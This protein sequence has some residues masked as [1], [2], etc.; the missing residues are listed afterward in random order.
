MIPSKWGPIIHFFKVDNWAQCA[1]GPWG[2]IVLDPTVCPEKMNRWGWTP[3]TS[4]PGAQLSVL[5]KCSVGPWAVRPQGLNGW[6][7]TV[8]GPICLEPPHPPQQQQRPQQQA[9]RI[10]LTWA[11]LCQCLEIIFVAGRP[12]VTSHIC[13][14]PT[15]LVFS[16]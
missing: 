14:S 2:L 4:C 3:G 9:L 5:K 12:K 11:F 10:H 7:Q 1:V 6:G 13:N 15:S 8:W 16:Q